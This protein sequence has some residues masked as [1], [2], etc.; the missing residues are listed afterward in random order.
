MNLWR[1]C[2]FKTCDED[3]D[4]VEDTPISSKEITNCPTAPENSCIGSGPDPF[5]NYM[6]CKFFP[7]I[8]HFIFFNRSFTLT[9]NF[10]KKFI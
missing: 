5:H 7:N 3:A 9:H 2:V 1:H 8:L 6:G 10:F 4:Y